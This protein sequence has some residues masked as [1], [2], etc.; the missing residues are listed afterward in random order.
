MYRWHCVT[1]LHALHYSQY[2]QV[3]AVIQLCL[4]MSLFPFSPDF[5]VTLSVFQDWTFV[6]RSFHRQ[7]ME[8]VSLP[9]GY[10]DDSSDCLSGWNFSHTDCTCGVSLLCGRLGGSSE[11][12]GWRKSFRTAHRTY[13]HSGSELKAH[14]CVRLTSC[15]GNAACICCKSLTCVTSCA[16]SECSYRRMFCYIFDNW[17]V[18]GLKLL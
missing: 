8:M 14:R 4:G 10:V 9:Y 15:E 5:C 1:L 12:K 13:W 3:S 6:W 17:I 16:V 7:H 2:C 18:L 11:L